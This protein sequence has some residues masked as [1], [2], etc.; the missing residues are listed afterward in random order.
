MSGIED[1]IGVA[2]GAVFGGNLLVIGL[3][4]LLMMIIIGAVLRLSFEGMLVMILPFIM[5]CALSGYLP[6]YLM[7][8]VILGC[9]FIIFMAFARLINR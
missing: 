6:Y 9:G 2:F 8:A 4:G 7:Y 3:F 1:L 5:L